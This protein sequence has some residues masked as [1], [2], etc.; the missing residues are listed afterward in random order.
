MTDGQPGCGRHEGI[1]Q[2]GIEVVTP[3]AVALELETRLSVSSAS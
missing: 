2:G 1:V 3:G